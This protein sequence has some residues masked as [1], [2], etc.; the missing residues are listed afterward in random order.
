MKVMNNK[1]RRVLIV[2]DNQAIHTDF[3][4]ILEPRQICD[5]LDDLESSIFDDA[6]DEIQ[7]HDEVEDVAFNVDSAFQGQEALERVKTALESDSRYAMAFVD[8]RMP[9]GWNGV[10]SIEEMWKVDPELQIVICTAFSDHSWDQIAAR[11]GITDRLLILKKPFDK[12]E[13]CQ[14][15]LALT[16]KSHLFEQAG[17]KLDQLEKM[18]ECKTAELRQEIAERKKIEEELVEAKKL[19]QHQA[20]FDD[21]TQ[22]MNRRAIDKVLRDSLDTKAPGTTGLLF[23]DIDHFKNVNDTHG[24]TVGDLVLNSV[25]ERLQ[26]AL[27]PSDEV[28]RYGGEEFIVLLR[29]CDMETTRIVGE[30]LRAAVASTPIE[31]EDITLEI[32]VSVG[33]TVAD[34]ADAAMEE[35]VARAD[36]AMYEAKRNG[37]NRVEFTNRAFVGSMSASEN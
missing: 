35:V 31:L 6:P 5:G 12:I 11:L 25:S 14:L 2:D 32:T 22:M 33:A 17:F 4:K 21:T 7:R 16:E 15:A 27:R 29:E 28:G 3:R 1:N 20:S 37:R 10:R 8:M 24:H 18:V 19:L 9:P 36:K 34:A 30:R 13:V 26:A 23:I